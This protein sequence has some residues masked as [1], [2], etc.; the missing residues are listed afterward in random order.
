MPGSASRP[1][2]ARWFSSLPGRLVAAGVVTAVLFGAGYAGGLH[3]LG[4]R[5]SVMEDTGRDAGRG[6]DVWVGGIQGPPPGTV[7]AAGAPA[8]GTLET[9]DPE[10]S[11]LYGLLLESQLPSGAIRVKPT[12]SRIIPYFANLAAMALLDEQPGKVKAYISWYLG[13]LNRPD[14]WGLEGTIYD[15]TVGRES[16]ERST[17]GY[18]SADSYAATFLTLVRSYLDRTGDKAFIREH[19][20]DIRLVASVITGL[21]DR[22]GL[23]WATGA[24][25]EKYLMDNC[26]NYRGLLDFAA[27][28]S[29]MGFRDEASRTQAAAGRVAQGVETR[30][31]NEKRGNYDWGLY[32]FWVGSYRVEVS[33]PSQWRDWYPDTTAQIFPI[34]SGLLRPSDERAVFLYEN[35]N[36]WHPEWVNQVKTDPHPWSVLGYAAAM[37]GDF[38]RA[39]A[40]TESTAAV[41]LAEDGPY[42][43]LS[44]ELGYHLLTIGLLDAGSGP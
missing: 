25:R 29:A 7:L 4:G 5:V 33:R 1:P 14:R 3:T 34:V 22:D 30:L 44:W 15:Y 8:S 41:Y 13:K 11:D 35:F 6:G 28:L 9:E 16:R 42:S 2:Q 38:E 18:D 19:M 20:D 36:A 43:G 26:E 24:K 37:M 21:Q 10:S 12:D 40:F 27:I 17:R 31:W 23:V 32:T 39:R